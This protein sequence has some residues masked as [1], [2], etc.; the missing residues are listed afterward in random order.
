MMNLLYRTLE[1]K[2]LLMIEIEC[3]AD[4]LLSIDISG[5]HAKEQALLR[6]I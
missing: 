6:F 5:F 2:K 4:E 3:G 1:L